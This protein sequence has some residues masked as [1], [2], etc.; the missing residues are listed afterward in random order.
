MSGPKMGGISVPK[1]GGAL[2]AIGETFQPDLHTGTG[3]LSVPIA[4]PEGRKGL[5]P[6]MSLAY[7]TGAGNG[8]FGLGWTLGIPQVARRT[9]RGIPRY[10]DALDTFVLSGA[11]ELVP[12]P[13][14]TAAPAAGAVG[15]V[16][17]YRPR[18]EAAF[19]R[20]THVTGESGDYWDVRSKDGLRSYYG[21]PRP[22]DASADW[23]DPAIVV[24]PAGGIFTWLLSETSDLL[25]NRISYTYRP[26]PTGSPQ[27]YLA[28]V[29]YADYGDKANP[30]YLVS[31]RIIYQD[32][33]PDGP[34]QRPDPF[35]DRRPGFELR[36]T[37]RAKRIEIWIQTDTPVL[38]TSIA[39]N[40]V[41][42]TGTPPS[43]R[44]SL[45][46]RIQVRGHDGAAE[47]AR[48]PLEF[49]Y[50]DWDPASRR[51]RLLDPVLP[52]TPLGTGGLELADAF[53]DGLPSL[54][55]LNE[56]ARYWRN[57]G[58]GL[59][60]LPRSIAD[61]PAGVSLDQPGTRLTDMNGDGRPELISSS[62]TRTASWSLAAPR[63]VPG[64]QA[65]FDLSSY[66]ARTAPTFPLTDP[67]VRLLDLDGDHQADVLRG[68]NPP[69][70]AH[71]DG[72]AGFSGLQRLPATT[73]LPVL[74]FTDRRVQTADMTGDGLTDIVFINNRSVIYRPNL[75]YGRFGLPVA[76]SGAPDFSDAASYTRTGFD[77]R[78][79][80]IGDVVGDGT[81]DVLYIGEGQVTLWVNQSGNGFAA[82]VIVHGTPRTTDLTA[83]RL[84]D[85][86][87]TGAPGIVW[88]GVGQENRTAFLDLTGG[89][90]P[91]LL[92]GIDNHAGA[93]TTMKY[94]TSTAYAT[95]DRTA[96]RP[97]RT[98]LP[99]PVH[100]VASV[101]THDAFAHTVLNTRF[102]YHD[103]YWD[104]GDREFRGFARVEQTDALLPVTS[105]PLPPVKIE[106]LDPLAAPANVPIGFDSAAAGNLLA[107]FSF[108]A[109]SPGGPSTLTT[110]GDHPSGGG[111]SAADSWTVWN[112]AATTTTT[113]LLASTLPY[114]RG[115]S[116]V[117]V[118][119]GAGGCGIV[120]TFLPAHTGP[121]HVM[122]S[123]WLYVMRGSVMIG[124]GDGGNTSEDAVCAE[125]GRWMLME[126]GNQSTPGNEIVIYSASADGAEFYIDH[127]WVREPSGPTEP[128]DSPPL[129]TV[130]WFHP[131][132][133]GPPH[134]AW[135]QLDFSEEY[136]PGDP[137]LAVHVDYTE[138]P[139]RLPRPSLR[140]GVRAMRGRVLRTETYAQDSSARAKSPYEVHDFAYQVAPVLDG[141][142]AEHADWQASPV[143]TVHP[144]MSRSV[145]WERGIDPMTRLLLTGGYDSYGRPHARADIGVPRGRDPRAPGAACLATLTATEYA[146]RD[147]AGIYLVDRVAR[148]VRYE[149]GDDGTGPVLAFGLATLTGATT[150]NLRGLELSYYDGE[151][152]TG[153]DLGQLG[154]H[155]LPVRTE[156][157][158]ITPALLT[159][160]GQP[161]P[162]GTGITL[163]PYLSL[164]GSAA[165]ASWP[166][167][168]PAAFQQ[169]ITG[170]PDTRGPHLG[171]SWHEDVGDYVAGYYAQTSRVSYDIHNSPHIGRGLVT[172]S[173][174]SVGAEIAT[175]YDSYQLLPISITDPAGL[176]TTAD[177]DYRLLRPILVT[178]T[179]GNRTAVGYTPLG[180]VAFTAQ[181]GKIAGAEAD[182]VAQP[183]V[184]YEYHLTAW[185]DSAPTGNS[186][187]NA[188][189]PISVTTVRRVEHRWTIVDRENSR[190]TAAG[191]PPLTDRDIAALFGPEEQ[192]SH[193]ER[194]IHIVEFSD[195]L[196]RL[197]QT[198][199]QADDFIIDDLGLTDDPAVAT[200]TVTGH[201][202]VP[203]SPAV[204]VSGW[205]V[206]DNKGRPVIGYE[207]FFDTGYGY[208][209]PAEGLLASLARTVRHYDPRGLCIRTVT[210]DGTETLT[211]RGVPTSLANPDG[212]EPTPWE[213]CTYDG[214]DNAGRTHPTVSLAFADHWNTP[215]STVLDAF[216]RTTATTA[217]NGTEIQVTTTSYDID[218]HPLTVTDPLG[219]AC[220]ATFYDLVGQAWRTW[221]LDAGTTHTIRDAAGA[222]VE[223][224]DDKA[225]LTL[226]AF[227][228]AHR[229]QLG[230]ASEHSGQ[231]P[232]LRLV[233][234]YGDDPTGA[235]LTLEQARGA[236]ALGRPVLILDEAGA[237]SISGY[238]L[239]GNPVTVTRRILQLELL[240]A[241][242]PAS[243]TTGGVWD[244]TSYA[245]DWQPASGKNYTEH[246]DALLDPISYQTDNAWD[247]LGRKTAETGPTDVTGT[248]SR[249]DY[250]YGRGGGITAIALDDTPYL[251]SVAYDAHGRRLLA[252]LGN[253]LLLRYRYDP[254]TFRLSRL[255]T[256]NATQLNPVSWQ[257]HGPAQQDHTYRYDLSGNLLTI[258]DRTPACGI[259]PAN[260]NALDR[261]FR[262]DPL[263]RLTAAT[264]RE[265]DILPDQPWLETPRSQDITRARAYTETYDYD[266]AGNLLTLRHAA[267]ATAAGAYTRTYTATAGSNRLA[268]LATGSIT[269][270]YTYDPAGNLTSE[271]TSRL[272][273]WD[274]ANRLATYRTQ[275]GPEP[276]VYAQYR[277]DASG[278]RTIKLVRN[279][280]GPDTVTIYIGAG[281]ERTLHT[282]PAA[283]APTTH[284]AVHIL[285]VANRIATSRRGDPLPGDVMPP[286]I[287]TL[288]DHLG[289]S[290]V[291]TDPA[292]SP[293]NKEEY[294]PYG[295]TSFGSYSRKRYRFTGKE[296]NEESSLSYHGARYY[297]SWQC[298]W[299][300]CDPIPTTG[301]NV[302][303]YCHGAP[304][305][306]RDPDGRSPIP[307]VDGI[308]KH[309]GST[310]AVSPSGSRATPAPTQ[311]STTNGPGTLPD[312]RTDWGWVAKETLKQI[313]PFSTHEERVQKVNAA[314]ARNTDSLRRA[315]LPTDNGEG[316]LSGWS[317]LG[318]TLGA[319]AA[320]RLLGPVL[321][322]FLVPKPVSGVRSVVLPKATASTEAVVPETAKSPLV[323]D[324]SEQT[325]PEPIRRAKAL[326]EWNEYLGPNQTN[327]HPRT[328]LPDADRLV[329]SD[330]LRSIRFGQHEM[331]SSRLHYHMEEWFPDPDPELP[332]LMITNDVRNVNK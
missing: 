124:T 102:S 237:H 303:G 256:A 100:V 97:W 26:D 75:G 134:G 29:R 252:H 101:T 53:G 111:P 297:A 242:L 223:Q 167:V 275:A 15:T 214:N 92:T 281:F 212:M 192:T 265:T 296:R 4:L 187:A 170:A 249:Y 42:E 164:D 152:F 309:S 243:G 28:G 199:T 320:G 245:A 217:R 158:V 233:T 91:Y 241:A 79:L 82:P 159:Q 228:R 85:L 292:G 94:A 205:T 99:F 295:E 19:A 93:A 238:N 310:V 181:L 210:A 1:G 121:V 47:Q 278:T 115:G 331:N 321:N 69:M 261:R 240:L 220:A 246:A 235:G 323:I 169:A 112:N 230:W 132:P 191:Q 50:S 65:G 76:M 127:A 313:N 268:T 84:A 188:R 190:R 107:N 161:G 110:T 5:T 329:S 160:S 81:A 151:A 283:A 103:G 119:T 57:R 325:L 222:P 21:T 11:E 225:A 18:T 155:G 46:G 120:Q 144:T 282:L 232:T 35:S 172:V 138:L 61:T 136:W 183:G 330:G 153:L 24:N 207:P 72:H 77:P 216:G 7:S 289:S 156:H 90:K 332:T 224:R 276:S 33:D 48:P 125:T 157:L 299:V 234:V 58:G 290:T 178:D 203:E 130:T 272:F 231:T 304:L 168:Y 193:P 277:Y 30:A 239:D 106:P 80:L 142:T 300:T 315:G 118:T 266:R 62:A 143:V 148:T 248:R 202:A 41:D 274:H 166:A 263:Y 280:N 175:S 218:G 49:T 31:V 311:A 184:S 37:L 63:D 259:P 206:Y 286:I 226:S 269:A 89:S 88:S 327:V 128:V 2:T 219:R 258:A 194:F 176:T 254:Q 262:Y 267:D 13:E 293:L 257:P 287:Y 114:G 150:T 197:L 208:L 294:T 68:G 253:G 288:P 86:N 317:L 186:P 95:A 318:Q 25:G 198:R 43:N 154:D 173:L 211:L 319:V 38:A 201:N 264:G 163:P 182:T 14:G 83:V 316:I 285:D 140:E 326:D 185:D 59:F 54:L 260:P 96:G 251:Q 16:S 8:A 109:P 200:G 236:N 291:V 250:S 10:D 229:P 209:G 67:Q 306:Q 104:P 149:C 108:D 179:N 78:R 6:S 279:Q 305:V 204:V 271:T 17:R 312:G 12:V 123:A 45:L 20:I 147:D 36:T 137:Q 27:L 227:D 215:S 73:D 301:G 44:V 322:R 122:S 244:N 34:P 146:T 273:E 40:Y 171:Y 117:H 307:V 195:G 131:G 105:E 64:A 174:D 9:D 165:P 328:G 23:A 139:D 22:A 177:Y 60:D 284:D 32:Q 129:R 70:M 66:T 314:L 255:H 51:F 126:A 213:T 133:V 113:E 39:L 145:V 135:H 247:A 162:G 180:L 302:Y 189:Q 52:P 74:D 324:V 308:E 3:N 55:Q 141:R 56:T 71:G 87:G 196:G 298:R 116:M 270:S 98:T 221:L